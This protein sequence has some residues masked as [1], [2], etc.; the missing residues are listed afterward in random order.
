M[1]EEQINALL[2]YIDAAIELRVVEAVT[3]H[4]TLAHKDKDNQYSRA[5]ERMAQ[6]EKEE[7]R[8]CLLRLLADEQR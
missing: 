7:A 6:L 3:A 8:K 4:E 1:N 2:A 5:F